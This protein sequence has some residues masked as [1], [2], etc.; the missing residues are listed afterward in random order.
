MNEQTNISQ[1]PLAFAIDTFLSHHRALGKRFDSEEA[2][3]RLLNRYL[4]E[5]A[6]E[7]ISAVTP[8]LL[9]AFVRSRPRTRPRSYNHLVNVLQRFFTWLERQEI[10]TPSPCHL[11]PRRCTSQPTPFLFE[12]DQVRCLLALA[13]QLPDGR[14]THRRG[15]TY[16]L[17]FAL[18]YALGLRVSE[19]A[20]LYRQDVDRQRQCLLILQSIFAKGLLLPFGTKV[21][22][23][24]DDHLQQLIP[25]IEPSAEAPLF[26][27]SKN[28]RQP[29]YPKTISRTFQ[30][31]VMQM[32]LTIPPGVAPP[33]L[34]CLR[35]S[36]AVATL[37]HWYRSGVDPAARLNNLSTFLGHVNPASTTVY[38]TITSELL[39]QANI[40]FERYAAPAVQGE[41][42]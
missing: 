20:R 13:E 8:P 38:L 12:P 22:Q 27:L 35:H 10:L 29:I 32:G 5:Q 25:G 30:H 40:R 24:L 28:Q 23:G 3:L 21:G 33:R 37:L 9:Q 31:L 16:R 1:G 34:H 36:F 26:S 19:V 18:M 15:A 41:K 11:Q 2:A 17:I 4:L 39:E 6:V 14:N 7:T 42:R